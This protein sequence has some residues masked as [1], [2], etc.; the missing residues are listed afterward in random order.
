MKRTTR[1]II[2]R[3]LK[4]SKLWLFL[5]W[6]VLTIWTQ[7]A[8]FFV[9]A[10]FFLG[11]LVVENQT[12]YKRITSTLIYKVYSPVKWFVL[13][14]ILSIVVRTFFIEVYNIPSGSMEK[15]LIPGDIIIV[16]KLT[17]GMDRPTSFLN[18]ANIGVLLTQFEGVK[19]FCDQHVLEPMRLPGLR[20]V[21][22]ND[23]LVFHSPK[24]PLILVKRIVGCAGDTMNVE[25]GD[26]WINGQLIQEQVTMVNEWYV[27]LNSNQSV[28]SLLDSLDIQPVATYY[29]E[30][31]KMPKVAVSNIEIERIKACEEVDSVVQFFHYPRKGHWDIYPYNPELIT[32]NDFWG[33]IVV[34][35]KGMEIDL[36]PENLMWYKKIITRHEHHQLEVKNDSVYIDDHYKT[37]YV[38]E[39]DYYF[40]MGDSR[41]FSFDSRF[42][43]FVPF[44][45]IIG[46]ARRVLVSID[47]HKYG[48]ARWRSN[49]T[50][51]KIE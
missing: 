16:D 2:L 34:P 9:F 42:Y 31:K 45:H 36:T 30:N 23:I 6:S 8:W 18:L 24:D 5:F 38:F 4:S 26:V 51:K 41:H 29:D 49:R 28:F 11:S 15:T 20:K 10:L 12:W 37:S 25:Q 14:V 39:Q 35:Q 48:W 46:T 13:I 44:D 3:H 1:H 33:P 47:P 17:L 7:I 50:L 43:G 21:Q 19:E 40:A 32:S 27:Y 22:R